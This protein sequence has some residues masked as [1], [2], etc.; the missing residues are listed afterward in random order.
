MKILL[1]AIWIILAAWSIVSGSWG[2]TNLPPMP[3]HYTPIPASDEGMEIQRQIDEAAQY[4]IDIRPSPRKLF[5]DGLIVEWNA[6]R[7]SWHI[8]QPYYRVE[9][10]KSMVDGEW[11]TIGYRSGNTLVH[12]Y[13]EGFYRVV[14]IKRPT[15][16]PTYPPKR[17]P[18][19]V[20]DTRPAGTNQISG[21]F[22]TK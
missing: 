6:E 17:N 5:V 12:G 13:P 7:I 2:A 3:P 21:G 8:E 4:E 19:S 9:W 20:P 18:L 11:K 10:R 14:T 15:L 22:T 16:P 1:I